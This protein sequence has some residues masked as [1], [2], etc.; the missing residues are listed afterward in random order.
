MARPP[1]KGLIENPTGKQMSVVFIDEGLRKAEH[2]FAKLFGK[3]WH[4]GFPSPILRS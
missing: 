1:Q 4:A 3:N 2:C